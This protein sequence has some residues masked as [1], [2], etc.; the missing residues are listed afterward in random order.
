MRLR[1]SLIVILPSLRMKM[2]LLSMIPRE[3]ALTTKDLSL[4]AE[5][6]MEQTISAAMMKTSVQETKELPVAFKS[7]MLM[8]SSKD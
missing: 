1:V 6:T 2:A 8:A 5:I 4:I 3:G 7:D